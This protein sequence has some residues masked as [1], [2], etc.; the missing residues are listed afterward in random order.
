VSSDERDPGLIQGWAYIVAELAYKRFLETNGARDDTIEETT[1]SNYD[2]IKSANIRGGPGVAAS[3]LGA[4]LCAR[5]AF[6]RP[7]SAGDLQKGER[8]IPDDPTSC[9]D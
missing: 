5:H 7:S 1:C 8:Y 2:A 3:G 6:H 4:V 9:L